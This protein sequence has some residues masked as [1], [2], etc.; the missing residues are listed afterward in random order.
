M[1][2]LKVKY[3]DLNL[4]NPLIVGSS[5][6]TKTIDGLLKAQEAGAGAV[7]LKSLFEEELTDDI[8]LDNVYHPE[9]YEFHINDACKL[10]GSSKYIDF[11]KK[12]RSE[13]FIPVIA[14]VNCLGGKW[15]V[16]FAKEIENAGAAAIELNVAYI[17][18]SVQEDSASIEKRYVSVVE[19]VKKAVNIPVSVKIGHY[20]TSIPLMVK[21]IKEAGADGVVM[22]NKFLRIGIDIENMK[23][24]GL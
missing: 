21:K 11:I 12:A 9:A 13:L 15:W 24:T 16:D 10:Y 20:F 14:S 6:L 2:N 5:T 1:G 8:Y 23:F 17:P 4:R 3:L 7:V 18:F 19:A 22:F